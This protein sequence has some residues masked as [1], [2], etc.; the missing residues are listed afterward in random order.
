MEEVV[1]N[2]PVSDMKQALAVLKTDNTDIESLIA[3]FEELTYLAEDL[4]LANG[5]FCGIYFVF[6][7]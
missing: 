3:A 5:T 6:S 1:A 2:D 4:D 7:K